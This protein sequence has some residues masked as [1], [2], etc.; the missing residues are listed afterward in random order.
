MVKW[1][2]FTRVQF[3]HRLARA[4]NLS[5]SLSFTQPAGTPSPAF[6]SVLRRDFF[7]EPHYKRHL[8]CEVR[9]ATAFLAPSPKP[10]I[11][12]KL[13]R[14]I[15]AGDLPAATAPRQ[16]YPHFTPDLSR[17]LDRLRICLVGSKEPPRSDF[18]SPSL[19][20]L[21]E[22]CSPLRIVGAKVFLARRRHHRLAVELGLND[23]A[24]CDLQAVVGTGLQR[25]ILASLNARGGL[26]Q[27]AALLAAAFR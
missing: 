6:D 22:F 12:N 1:W 10:V 14:A 16:V 11:L 9:S 7:R 26:R 20:A 17:T 3:S 13:P 15:A 8:L 21:V 5:R 19:R 27:H 23:F 4:R 18:R 25:G 2:T 24:F